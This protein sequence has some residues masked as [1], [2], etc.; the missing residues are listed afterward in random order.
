M[1]PPPRGTSAPT[2][3]L[4][5][6]ATHPPGPLTPLPTNLLRAI[7]SR[8]VALAVAVAIATFAIVITIPGFPRETP[9]E[10]AIAAAILAKCLLAAVIPRRPSFPRGRLLD[11]GLLFQLAVAAG[12]AGLD[13]AIRTPM[14]VPTLASLVLNVLFVAF[15]LALPGPPSKLVPVCA[16][17]AAL[18]P[19]VLLLGTP[20]GR[21]IPLLPDIAIATFPA[22]VFAA[23]GAIAGTSL[24]RARAALAEAK[25]LGRYELVELLGKGGMGEV[26]R[27]KHRMLARPAAIKFVRPET[28][29]VAAA[30]ADPILDVFPQFEREAKITAHLTSPHTIEIYDFGRT[31]EG[32]LCYVMEYLE[33]MDLDTLVR[34]YGPVS[35]PRAVYLLKQACISLAEAHQSGLVHRDVKPAN[36]YVCRKGL[37]HDFIKVLDFG[38]VA[39][40]H[41][42]SGGAVMGTPHTM[43]PEVALGRSADARADLYSLGCVAYWLLTGRHVFNGADAA[44]IIRHQVR[45]KP[46]PPSRFVKEPIP[47]DLEILVLSCLQK[48]PAD[49]ITS[50]H[51]LARRL[52]ECDV[53]PVWTP[54]QAMKW[55]TTT[56]A[57]GAPAARKAGEPTTEK[58]LNLVS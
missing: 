58:V 41:D 5:R 30:G 3:F 38:L 37:Q 42:D 40:V 27:A 17:A 6:P 2:V 36:I 44:E 43:A 4:E 10:S 50:A 55:W 46:E 19:A 11:F 15:P 57:P 18:H 35:P 32:A 54:G 31:E 49:R 13:A 48:N 53:R 23:L 8:F 28:L 24:H 51:E 56:G 45:S 33:G 1:V 16:C 9:I 14:T 29:G 7:P 21:W 25:E 12:I 47:R 22:F 20:P 52:G 39:E 34:A 26:W